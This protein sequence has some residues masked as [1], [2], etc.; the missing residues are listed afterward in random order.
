[1]LLTG[2]D[3]KMGTFP[4]RDGSSPPTVTLE[5]IEGD[6]DTTT[7]ET[8]PTLT[9]TVT[10]TG[11]LT[12]AATLRTTI[13]G[14]WPASTADADLNIDNITNEITFGEIETANGGDLS[15]LGSGSVTFNFS[16]PVNLSVGLN[17]LKMASFRPVS[18]AP[19]TNNAGSLA[20]ISFT[21]EVTVSPQDG[22][23]FNPSFDNIA[24]AGNDNQFPESVLPIVVTNSTDPVIE[25]DLADQSFLGGQ[26]VLVEVFRGDSTDL[27][28]RLNTAMVAFSDTPDVTNETVTG[29]SIVA[30]GLG[31]VAG[32]QTVTLRATD[33]AGNSATNS[34]LQVFVNVV[35]DATQNAPNTPVLTDFYDL[36]TILDDLDGGTVPG[37]NN[38]PSQ[39][40]QMGFDKTTQTVWINTELGNRTFQIDPA[41]GQ[42]NLL[43]LSVLSDR[44]NDPGNGNP[45]ILAVENGQSVRD[46]RNGL[47]VD[48]PHGVFF[49]FDTALTPRIWIAHRTAGGA[50]ARIEGGSS[51]AQQEAAEG[52]RLSFYDLAQNQFVTYEFSESTFPGLGIEDLHAVTVDEAGVIWTVSTHS[53]TVFEVRMNTQD[54]TDRTARVIAHQ[55]PD[56][57]GRTGEAFDPHGID[58]VVDER[59]GEK[60]V[61]LIAEGGSGRLAL[62]R[63]ELDLF[64]GDDAWLTWDISNLTGTA[65]EFEGTRG[66]FLKIDDGE[67]PGIPEDDVIVAT[68]PVMQG[69]SAAATVGVVHR[70]DP[71]TLVINP[72]EST[73]V[74]ALAGGDSVDVA[75][76][77][78]TEQPLQTTFVVPKIPGALP[79][80]YVGGAINQP[81][82]DREG[83]IYFIDRL[84]SVGRFD[85]DEISD[86]VTDN[87]LRRANDVALTT[88]VAR[89]SPAMVVTL[90]DPEDFAVANPGSTSPVQEFDASPFFTD[91]GIAVAPVTQM[92]LSDVS[93]LTN[94]RSQV[95]GLDLYEVANTVANVPLRQSQGRGAFRGTFN[96]TNVLYASLALNDDITTTI[97]S[98]TSRRRMSV[99]DS[100]GGGR[101][102]FQ[103]VR[104]GSLIMTSRS[105]GDLFDEQVNLTR[106]VL[107]QSSNVLTREQLTFDG[108]PSAVRESDG[109]VHVFGKS[110]NSDDTVAHVVHYQFDATAGTWTAQELD[111]PADAILAGDPIAFNDGDRGPAAVLT[112]SEGHLLVFRADGSTVDLTEGVNPPVY[113]KPGVVDDP[114]S[115]RV[116][117]YGADM[118]GDVV[119]YQFDRTG[120]PTAATVSAASLGNST[121]SPETRILQDVDA[122]VNGT[123]RHVFG[124]D[125]HS[126]MVHL[127]V[128]GNGSL[129]LA[130]NVSQDLADNPDRVTGYFDF[131]MPFVARVYSSLAPVVE[132]D[133]S[134]SVYGT[135]GGDLVLFSETGDVWRAS[136]L[137]KDAD[138]TDDPSVFT[139]ANFVFG[140][141]D[142]Y[143]DQNGDRHSLQINASG[144]VVEYVFDRSIGRF[145]TQ[146]INLARN[147][148]TV[149]LTNL[150]APADLT[151]GATETIIDN[152]GAGY[153][154]VLGNS[155]ALAAGGFGG[156]AEILGGVTGS[157]DGTSIAQWEFTGLAAG[158][159]RVS[160]TWTANANN[161]GNSVFVVIADGETAKQARVNQQQTP[162]SFTNTGALWQDLTTSVTINDGT[163]TVLLG[164]DANGLVIADAIRIERIDALQATGGEAAVAVSDAALTSRDV[165]ASFNEAVSLLTTAFGLTPE[166]IA[167]LDGLTPVIADLSGSLLGGLCGDQ[168]HLDFNAAGYGW[169]IDATPGLNDEFTDPGSGQL[170]AQTG[171]AADGRIDLLTVLLHEMSHALGSEHEDASEHS[172]L[173]EELGTGERRLPESD[174]SVDDVDLQ[175]T[176]DSGILD[177]L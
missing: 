164:D 17:E 97:F 2:F 166:Q 151:G 67:T 108:D 163:L 127:E 153:S 113:A 124:T 161:A 132:A 33:L 120:T 68:F 152:G 88:T 71:G 173:S 32:S 106:E 30:T 122:V 8:N 34:D 58:V 160:A 130:E 93:H 96:A 177:V 105:D 74:A 9:G 162:R 76:G 41:T 156:D 94:D 1:M 26:N 62:L 103:T 158:A 70:F 18:G 42:V 92:N 175:F 84:G 77:G 110:A 114:G 46:E 149:A 118:L 60:Y 116:Y 98:D 144:E 29:Q 53:N 140:A 174:A 80:M 150:D 100:P 142:A 101:M 59:T 36:T 64:E 157:N 57:I 112:T 125:G 146:N 31:N 39:V 24:L 95:A 172:L 6:T 141:S 107:L 145:S 155:A 102:A 79:G 89:N 90:L 86:V 73:S 51:A 135:N 138:P 21:F 169:H 4:G 35:G 147:N 52:G 5:S 131:Q 165:S 49:D 78:L 104:N 28:D 44:V 7:A 171:A 56:S 20:L 91:A 14:V 65:D 129:D 99:V 117:I 119:E 45:E 133:G 15:A 11:P 115:G 81:Y 54:Q 75:P 66:T 13:I 63:P 128:S 50:A 167:E 23:T 87:T 12:S 134:L 37:V 109:T 27:A 55:L 143:L 148:D 48:N 47:T 176:P 170:Q 139:P 3:G 154:V 22:D 25:F 16:L 19:I 82:L 111:A 159:Y 121:G 43:N 137:S 38:V 69:S 83:N 123:T 40:W 136:N 72:A 10:I 61:W 126:R 168:L 85:P